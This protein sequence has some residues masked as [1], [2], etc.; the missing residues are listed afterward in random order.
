MRRHHLIAVVVVLVV[1]AVI[2]IAFLGARAEA[3]FKERMDTGVDVARMQ[4]NAA[5]LPAQ[6]MH[7]MTFVYT[8]GE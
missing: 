8:D 2:K 3:E 6:T 1:G 5:K 4:S 7:D